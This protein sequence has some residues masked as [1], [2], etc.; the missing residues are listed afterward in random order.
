M[1]IVYRAHDPVLGRSVALKLLG[2]GPVPPSDQQRARFAREARAAAKLRHPGIVAVHEVGEEGGRP[3]LVMEL[4]DGSSLE[5]VL[6]AGEIPPRRVAEVVRDVA[7]ALAH[8]HE[9][10]VVHRDVK[11]ENILI[12]RAA[13]DEPRFAGRPRLTDFGLAAEPAEVGAGA[14]RLTVSGQMMGTPSYMAPEQMSPSRGSIGPPADVYGLGGVLYRALAGRPPFDGDGL[15]QLMAAVMREEPPPLRG[16]DLS[17]HA[18]LETITLRCLEKSPAR[19]YATATALADDLDRFVRGDPID[20]RPPTGR[21]RL[22]RWVRRNRA[23]AAVSGTLLVAAIAVA[24]VGVWALLAVRGERLR[25]VDEARARADAAIGAFDRV[26][27]ASPPASEMPD[28]RRRR[29]DELLAAGLEA[30][31]AASTVVALDLDDPAARRAAFDVAMSTGEVALLGQQWSVA[32]GVFDRALRLGVDDGAAEAAKSRVAIERDNVARDHR[33]VIE[34]V[35]ADARRGELGRRFGGREAAVFTLVRFPEAQTVEILARVL[36]EVTERLAA[37]TRR[38]YLAA[39]SPDADERAAGIGPVDGL[40]A[41]LDRWLGVESGVRIDPVDAERIVEAQRRLVVR[42]VR[43]RTASIRSA[44][45]T[46]WRLVASEQERVVGHEDLETA[47]LC[48]EALGWLGIREGAVGPL[49]RYLFA[50][51]DERRAGT[52]GVALRLLGGG[53]ADG[54][55]LRAADQDRFGRAGPYWTT[56]LPFLDRSTLGV[57]VAAEG[58][59]ARAL[60]ARGFLRSQQGELEAAI[61]DLDRAIELEPGLAEAWAARGEARRLQGQFAAALPDYDRAVELAPGSA[62]LRVGRANARSAAGD[63]AGAREDAQRAT[64]IQPDYARAWVVRGHVARDRD[65]RDARASLDRAIE[66]EPG[67]SLAWATRATAR[68]NLGDVAGAIADASRAIEL[69][70]RNAEAFMYR[71]NARASS[72]DVAG[73]LA[74][75]EQSIRIDPRRGSAWANRGNVRQSLGDIDGAIADFSKAVDLAPRTAMCWTNRGTAYEAKGDLRRALADHT[76]ALELDESIAIAWSNRGNVWYALGDY[77]KSIA[78]HSRAA[79]LDPGYAAA[80]GNRA[81]AR[82]MAGDVPGA[83]E[84]LGRAIA[85]D[86]TIPTFWINRA[87]VRISTGKPADAIPD[88]DRA[89]ALAPKAAMALVLRAEAKRATGDLPGAHEDADRAVGAA[90]R[91]FDAWMLRAELR[92]ADG[93]RAGADADVK[94]ALEL[95]PRAKKALALQAR[96]RSGG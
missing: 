72:G 24:L 8:A 80:F 94:R 3:F 58:G 66:L 40:A 93:N 5:A 47:Q 83:I 14:E 86:A 43:G 33:E 91:S 34:S 74:D 79:E 21:E 64:E 67:Q 88:L 23:A 6:A 53:E 36:D 10:G 19:R 32:T 81:N 96:I 76:K 22:V 55:A 73:G 78:D 11:P 45:A 57:T 56:I 4:V 20:A 2:T 39:G 61:A 48:A 18:D 54:Y 12:E 28:A 63:H 68:L 62:E 9:A 46:S 71:G 31:E 7:R 35:L 44:V 51:A 30:T 41:S 65:P 92:L 15:V 75:L 82:Y 16:D 85:V 1:G 27:A 29:E 95:A 60:L 52:A 17:I 84:D 42:S 37:V 50:E 70:P 87:S 89:L 69:D 38:V 26:V 77:R 49:G 59:D 90:P 13:P 25:V